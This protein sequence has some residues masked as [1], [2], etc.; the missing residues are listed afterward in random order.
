M[1]S[2]TIAL[3]ILAAALAGCTTA[4]APTATKQAFND[5]VAF[6]QKHT[7]VVILMDKSGQG[8]VAVLPKMQGRVMTS[9]AA[10]PN[11]YSFGW[12]NREFIAAGKPDA[13]MNAFGGED[14]FWLGPE[15]GQFSI[16]FDKGV[17]F[18]MDHWHTPAPVDTEAW[19]L[20]SKT[21]QTAVLRKVMQVKNY[22]GTVFDLRVERQVQVMDR[23]AALKSLGVTAGPDVKMVAYESNNKVVN[24]GKE[25]WTKETGLLSIW[26][27][28]MFNPSP[29]ITIVVPYVAG[30]E[31]QLGPVAN[32]SYFG[33]V[34]ADRLVNKDGVL[35]F[36]GDGKYR[37][38]IGLSPKR[39]KNLLG[40]Y[41][42]V[43]GVLTLVQY[44]KPEGVEGYVNS[45][46]QIQDQPFRGDVV[47]SYND[48]P[49]SPGGKPLGPFY[50]LETSSPAAA[51]APAQSILHTHRTVHFVGSEA[52]LDPIAK[53]TLGVT[54]A[55]IKSALR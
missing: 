1:D 17:P 36:S 35:Y 18:D 26:V 43:N 14:R 37:S 2:R 38:K 6:L 21:G 5:D 19:D 16:F 8:R 45:M 15:G 46:W 7:N 48:G 9:T 10:G 30:P 51:L 39:A 25:P 31:D 3:G 13:H 54:I 47:N 33:K 22:S 49:T 29:E 42:A 23:E 44:N 40:S 34:P 4:G 50:E 27:L 28:G 41:D 55:Q 12:I 52:Q 32:D 20:V 24:L 11:G 53:A